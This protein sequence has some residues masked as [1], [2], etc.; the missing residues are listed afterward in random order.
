METEKLLNFCCAIGRDLMQNGAEIYRVEESI[1]HIFDAYGCREAEVFAIPACIVVN[2]Q[3]GER[4][5]TKSVRV[6]TTANNLRKLDRLNALCRDICRETPPLEENRRRLEEVMAERQYPTAVSYLAYGLTAFFFTLFWGGRAVD[7]LMAFPCGLI[8]K[9]T[10]STMRRLQANVFFTNL[11]AGMLMA[12][13]PVLCHRLGGGVNV[14][15]CVIGAIML[16]VPGVAITNVV[17][18]VLAGDFV[19]A[20]SRLAEVLIVAMGIAVGVAMAITGVQMA[21][22]LLT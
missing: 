12:L 14:D 7:A 9:W 2:V 3:E 18:D 4:N 20:V 5:Y 17:R 10:L 1:Q 6:K 13:P 11:L 19:T 22:V 16:L 8:V 21:A 15:K